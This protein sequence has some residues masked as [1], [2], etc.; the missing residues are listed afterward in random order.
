MYAPLT[1]L[2]GAWCFLSRVYHSIMELS[3]APEYNEF[4]VRIHVLRVSAAILI[5][6]LKE[7]AYVHLDVDTNEMWSRG[8]AVGSGLHQE[9]FAPFCGA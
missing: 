6:I 8:A 4:W 7:M 5:V 9:H 3:L 1:C 2:L